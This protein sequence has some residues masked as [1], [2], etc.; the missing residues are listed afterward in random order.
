MINQIQVQIQTLMQK[1]MESVPV[2]KTN[3]DVKSTSDV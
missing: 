3:N 2:L 1:F